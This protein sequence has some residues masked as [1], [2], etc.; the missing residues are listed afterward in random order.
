MVDSL[1]LKNLKV[2]DKGRVSFS[3]VGSGI[4]F[5]SAVDNIIAARRIP[6]DRLEAGVKKNGEKVTALTELNSLLNS[7]RSSLADLRGQPTFGGAGNSFENKKVF[8]STT[9]TSGTPSAANT[10]IGVSV[11]NAASTGVHRV[12]VL[13]TAQAHRIS[14]G[15]ANSQ[16]A[17]LGL[18]LGGTSGSISGA[19][20]L[21]GRTIE[22]LSTD[23][24]I[25][26]RDRINAA[27]T[28]SRATGVTASIVS[29]SA[30]EQIL[31]LTS[32]TTGSSMTLAQSSKTSSLVA[33]RD[34]A[35][36]GYTA[37]TGTGNS[38][39]IQNAAGGTIGTITYDD[40]DS[41][42]SLQAKIS[43]VS[44][45]TG[46]VI[47]EGTRFK[48]NIKADDG[49]TIQLAN[50]SL[51]A[52]GIV[53]QLDF[54][55]D[56]LAD[57]GLSKDGGTTFAKELQQARNA[58]LRADGLVDNS[59]SRTVGVADASTQFGASAAGTLAITLPSGSPENITVLSSDTPGSLAAK[60]TGNAKLTA[61]GITASVVT[62]DAGR[63]RVEF[64]QQELTTTD[65]PAVLGVRVADAAVDQVEVS[66]D[67]TFA[68]G[69]N[70]VASIAVSA[71]D[72]LNG[73]RDA[74]NADA[75]LTAAGVT[76]SVV[77]D[78][79]KFKL[80]IQHD[81]GLTASGPAGLG[82]VTPELEIERGGNTV[83]DLFDGI[84]IN[85][86]QAEVGTEIRL[87]V[88]QDLNQVKTS[89][90]N[91]VE[92]YNA[93]KTAMNKHQLADETTGLAAADAGV[94]FADP[95]LASIEQGLSRTLGL[96]A[97][98]LSDGL[99]VL[100]EIGIDFIDNKSIT[101]PSK[102]DTLVINKSRLDE[103][104]LNNADQVRKLFEFDFSSSDPNV[105]LLGFN[106]STKVASGGY[107][108]DVTVTA[109]KITDARINGVEGSVTIKGNTLTATDK[110]GAEGLVLFYNGTASASGIKID[111]SQGVAHS[112]FHEVDSILVA[113][114]GVLDAKR[115]SLT[116]QNKANQERIKEMLVRL[117]SQREAL[118]KR[119]VSMESALLSLNN[120]LK[121]IQRQAEALNPKK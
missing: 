37:V 94:L 19:F 101:D 108:L 53:A 50:D 18:A 42:D 95:T 56:I 73:V 8:A 13:Q 63:S 89:I 83:N 58:R 82:L 26:L 5:R 120:T 29:V 121:T 51:G 34:A 78:G 55:G 23:T 31:V 113:D 92:A 69:K 74:I 97:Q 77:A 88:E 57:L 12:E 22:V 59:A 36:S 100:R 9:R 15:A 71:T 107:S 17:D 111:F 27:N 87:E 33:D 1:N 38:F 85:L 116:E 39:D 110:T 21:N 61:A 80:A 44:G 68:F 4:D 115:D 52:N 96:G 79:D 43:A 32:D 45:I 70:Q 91:F 54:P 25:G 109:G 41:L 35:F 10:L 62:D 67:L 86:F 81:D 60:I 117:K 114:T 106:G 104:L 119:F 93:L 102:A 46:T 14:A 84:T 98:G 76:A 112:L 49:G 40:S 7:L 72:S 2:D 99:R 16:T 47:A 11:T 48:L 103:K 20:E 3:G 24:L 118:L 30:T 90:T 105:A 6:I 75:G 28:G 65:G 64:R 66:G